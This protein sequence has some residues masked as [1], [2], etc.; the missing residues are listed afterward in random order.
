MESWITNLDLD[1][2]EKEY[3]PF[4]PS[5]SKLADIYIYI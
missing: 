5:P 3:E 4:L 2:R 1:G